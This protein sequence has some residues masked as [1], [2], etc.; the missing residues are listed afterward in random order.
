M[1]MKRSS[2]P[3]S[4]SRRA[5]GLLIGAIVLALVAT[6]LVAA[7]HIVDQNGRKVTVPDRATRMIVLQHQ[8]LDVLVQL[9]AAVQIVG[10]LS[11]WRQ[12][13]GARFAR[14]AP[15]LADLPTP[16]TLTKVDIEQTLALSPDVV[17][18]THYAPKPMVEAL[19]A[20]GIPVVQMAFFIVPPSERGKLDPVLADAK[21]AFDDG[22]AQAVLLLGAI[23]GRRE[24]A[25]QLIDYVHASRRLV[26]ER[27]ATVPEASRKTLFMANPGLATLGEGKYTSIMIRQAGGINVAASIKGNGVVTMEQLVEW[28]PEVVVV[29]DRHVAVADQIRHDPAWTK[30]RAVTDERIYVTPEYAKPWGH[31]LP[32][33]VALG[34]LWMAQKLHPELFRDIDLAARVDDYY[35]LFYD[36]PFESH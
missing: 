27:I 26:E 25:K 9:G 1:R 6:P 11:D 36:A 31:P 19:E 3:R 28:N 35:R 29:Q 15:R 17:I 30:I 22:L 4:A 24:R 20:A 8:S 34:E 21:R 2:S 33:A 13:L 16:G 12:Q 7:Q 32:E 18:L 10:V 23:T 14:F 5:A